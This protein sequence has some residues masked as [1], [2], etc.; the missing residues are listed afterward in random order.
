LRKQ[1]PR[2]AGSHSHFPIRA[3][4]VAD[5]H[6]IGDAP[7]LLLDRDKPRMLGRREPSRPAAERAEAF[8]GWA[9]AEL[10]HAVD[11]TSSAERASNVVVGPHGESIRK[12]HATCYF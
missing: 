7:H 9:S 11:S 12:R 4:G 1:G 3:I 6:R 5:L 2:D 10:F 8:E